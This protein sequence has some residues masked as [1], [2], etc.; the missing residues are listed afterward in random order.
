MKL[1]IASF[2]TILSLVIAG[3]AQAAEFRIDPKTASVTGG[4]DTAFE[5]IL[6]TEGA[7]TNAAD[8]YIDYDPAQIEII[9]RNPNIAG[10]QIE[11]GSMYEA[12]LNNNVENGTIRLYGFSLFNPFSG[13]AMFGRVWLRAIGSDPSSTLTVRFTGA[14]NTLDSNIAEYGSGDDILNGVENTTISFTSGF[15]RPDTT[16]PWVRDRSPLPGALDVAVSSPVSFTILDDQSGVDLNSLVVSIDGFEY[17]KNGENTFLAFGEPLRYEISIDPIDDFPTGAPITVS[18]SYADLDG[19]ASLNSWTFNNPQEEVVV[20]EEQVAEICQGSG[21]VSSTDIVECAVCPEA[22]QVEAQPV[23]TVAPV[24]IAKCPGTSVDVSGSIASESMTLP[25]IESDVPVPVATIEP[26]FRV[27]SELVKIEAFSRRLRLNPDVNNRIYMLPEV[28]YRVEIDSRELP[29]KPSSI[30]WLANGTWHILRPQSPQWKTDVVSDKAP[31]AYPSHLVITYEDNSVDRIDFTTVVARKGRVL[32]QDDSGN[33]VPA[34]GV[35]V[36]LI[37]EATG[38]PWK[39]EAFMQSNPQKTDENGE[40]GFMVPTGEYRLEIAS[41]DSRFKRYATSEFRGMIVNSKLE[42]LR[43]P[44]S[45]ISP[46]EDFSEFMNGVVDW[47][48][49]GNAAFRYSVDTPVVQDISKITSA[50]IF[51]LGLANALALGSGLGRLLWL[52]WLYITRP[53]SLRRRA[54]KRCGVVY[55]AVTKLPLAF[56][57]I[58]LLDADSGKIIRTSVS[59]K[60][61][62][63]LFLVEEGRYK[64]EIKK[65]GY[66]FPS[67]YLSLKKNDGVYAELYHGEVFKIKPDGGSI[68]QNVPIDPISP[69]S[70][71]SLIIAKR[72]LNH[73]QYLLSFACVAVSIVAFAIS[74]VWWTGAIAL[75]QIYFWLFFSGSRMRRKPKSWGVVAS[76]ATGSPIAQAVV[77]IFDSSYGK[78]LDMAVTDKK[79]RYSF[80]VGPAVYVLRA[81]KR[82]YEIAN[83]KT[84]DVSRGAGAGE[85]A[86]DIAMARNGEKNIAIAKKSSVVKKQ[87]PKEKIH[88]ENKKEKGP[89]FLNNK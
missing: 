54:C 67:A 70:R 80:L 52:P 86:I 46:T 81:E 21:Y 84:I 58:R 30:Q 82:G 65:P 31:G 7:S 73:V 59:D 36:V 34:A 40:Y 83:T 72:F 41:N 89:D 9:D 71:A 20:D 3:K 60:L 87:K 38:E 1:I 75:A 63:Y 5:I 76:K 64:L 55:D 8:I 51:A 88:I 50:S 39:G 29:K 37:D 25:I 17:S 79:G 49:Y 15:C 69:I 16:A 24:E 12:F 28:D 44:S 45:L 13:S 61:G 19:N 77:R 22:V 14:G 62:R 42:L 56:A 53:A 48:K 78:Q 26:E 32:Y 4:C 43:R 57:I 47:T 74:P 10:V 33:L 2:V 35:E 18:A 66:D 68:K 11:T 23:E 6:D 27:S 85:I